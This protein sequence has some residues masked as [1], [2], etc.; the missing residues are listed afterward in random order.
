MPLGP[1]AVT[2]AQPLAP[3]ALN[4]VTAALEP[5]DDTDGQWVR[6]F[7]WQPENSSQS[8]TTRDS[9]DT[10][11]VDPDAWTN[12]GIEVYDPYVVVAADKCSSFGFAAHDY[13]QR[14]LRL[15][16]YVT[17]DQMELEL[18][19][20]ALAQAKSYPNRYLVDSH[21]TN[22]TPSLTAAV[23]RVRGIEMLEQAVANCGAGQQAWIHMQPQNAGQLGQFTRR[24][25]NL[26]LT[27]LDSVVVPGVGYPGTA[28]GGAAP[29]G[30]TT[31]M[32]ATGP[33][34]IRRGPVEIWP[35]GHEDAVL[36]IGMD[37]TGALEQVDPIVAEN[38][39]GPALDRSKNTITIRAERLVAAY[40]EGGCQF[41]V[42]VNLDT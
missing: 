24:M 4:L 8:G 9:C 1:R 23:S 6:G 33:V 30:N 37:D 7:T 13:V 5:P 32:Y 25:G 2:G 16:D 39:L 27:P 18:W 10:T 31:W 21:V 12:Q 17:P 38:I 28:P 14:A 19:T 42:L 3:R 29:T 11:T 22:I 26:M 35:D 34:R 36:R 15:L 41:G 40:F 20:G